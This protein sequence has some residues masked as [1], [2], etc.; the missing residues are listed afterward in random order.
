MLEE[1]IKELRTPA[2][3][4]RDVP[5]SQVR[6]WMDSEETDVLGATYKFLMASEQTQRVKPPLDF[7]PVFDFILRYYAHCLKANPQSRW[8]DDA[9]SAAMDFVRW[10]VWM[11]DQER[12]RRYFET[13][14][15]RLAELYISGTSDVKDRIEHG[16]IEH[17]FERAAIREFF[18]DWR[19]N[20][21]LRRA[22]DEGVLWVEGG[23]MS[24]LTERR[25]G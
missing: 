20:P 15:A 8:A 23:G 17:L 16:V 4:Q 9:S 19:D 3:E 5:Q 7:D 18:S 22:Y 2:G 25:D 14:K 1:I 10:F 12:D 24:P 21:Q 11:W 13:I 6:R